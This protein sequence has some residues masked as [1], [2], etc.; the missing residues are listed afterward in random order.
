LFFCL[1][2]PPCDAK[3]HFCIVVE[4]AGR[5]EKRS[6]VT[7]LHSTTQRLRVHAALSRCSFTVHYYYCSLSSSTRLCICCSAAA[8]RV[9]LLQRSLVAKVPVLEYMYQYSG[10]FIPATALHQINSGVLELSERYDTRIVYSSTVKSG[11]S[12]FP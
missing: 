6:R 1:D 7:L 11:K 2:H 3:E 12:I 5:P 8:G 4:N 9:Y 10:T